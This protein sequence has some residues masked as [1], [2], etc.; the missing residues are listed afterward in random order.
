[1]AVQAIL[2]QEELLFLNYYFQELVDVVPWNVIMVMQSGWCR[3][4]AGQLT[5]DSC[6]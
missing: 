5:T 1:M 4:V 3:T 6:W 2:F